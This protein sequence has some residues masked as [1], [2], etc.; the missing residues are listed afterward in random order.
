VAKQQTVR[1]AA[2]AMHGRSARVSVGVRDVWLVIDGMFED[3]EVNNP[4]DALW[5]LL[6]EQ[7]FRYID[8]Y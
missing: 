6:A 2:Q 7:M 4:G 5:T 8:T 1:I 3:A